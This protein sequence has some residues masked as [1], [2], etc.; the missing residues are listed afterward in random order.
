MSK[1]RLASVAFLIALLFA[2]LL[3]PAPAEAATKTLYVGGSMALTGAYSQD[4][5]AILAAF[6]DYVKYVNETKLMAPWRAEKFPADMTLELLWRDD[7]LK[8]AKALTIYEELKAKGMLVFRVSGSPQ[9]LALKDRLNQDSMGATSMTSGAF[10]LT[11]P[12]TIFTHYPIYT[13]NLA[14][15]A[16]W[17]LEKWKENRKP[18]VA[19]LT[20][21]N[22][23]GKSIEVPEMDEYLKKAGY[24]FVGSPVCTA[25][26]Y[27]PANH[28]AYVAE[29]EEG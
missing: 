26:T 21:D 7:E 20:A 12:Q 22:A 29:G 11:P 1:V 9:A 28:P 4:V 15:I 3:S 23:M 10:L 16:D 8:P 25:G 2:A 18:R 19:Y 6:E 17:Y 13:D 24:E 27:C 5:A 14:A